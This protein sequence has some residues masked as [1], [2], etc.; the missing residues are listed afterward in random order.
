MNNIVLQLYSMLLKEAK[1]VNPNPTLIKLVTE[2]DTHA[3]PSVKNV[4]FT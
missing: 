1:T 3:N 4:V 2:T